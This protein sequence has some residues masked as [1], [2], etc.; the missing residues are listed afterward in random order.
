MGGSAGRNAPAETLGGTILMGSRVYAP[1]V[2]RFLSI[3]PTPGGNANVYDYCTAD[4]VNCSDLTG[5]WPDWGAVLNVVAVVAEVVATVVPG[6]IGT[7]A[8]F[9][10][11]GAYLATGNTEKATEMAITATA[12]LIGAGLAAKAAVKAVQY[13]S[14]IGRA[15]SGAVKTARVAVAESRVGRAAE[16]IL[17]KGCNCFIAG[18]LVDT[19]H[20]PVPIEQIQV[21]DQVWARDLDTGTNELREVVG[22]FNKQA[23]ALETITVSDGTQVVVTEEHPFYVDGEGWVLSGDLHVG[24]HLTQRNHTTTTIT[25][26]TRTQRVLTVYNFEVTGDH[27]YY[28][29]TAQLLVHNCPVNI[30]P[31]SVNQMNQEIMRGQAPKRVLRVDPGKIKGEQ[32]HVHF[33]GGHALN[34]DGT[35]KH[36]NTQLNRKEVAWLK[37]HQWG[38]PG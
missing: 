28:I 4:P 14:K 24:D 27:N 10:S 21:G 1:G 31:S 16:R 23:A 15:V 25:S 22:L 32:D 34:R 36:G 3:D 9:I 29:T 38:L 13:A 2:G 35:W 17:S 30:K 8:G 33:K 5:N 18:T 7:A 19:D 37:K 26:I 6:P 12:Q 11:A 20:G